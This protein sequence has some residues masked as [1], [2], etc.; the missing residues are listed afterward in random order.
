MGD[1][2]N[3]VMREEGKPDIYF[4]AHWSGSELP[5]I[6]R[7]TLA[8]KERWDD[9]PYLCRMVFC[10]LVKG[11]ESGSTGF[12]ISTEECD[13][14]HEYV[15]VDMTKQRIEVGQASWSFEEFVLCPDDDFEHW[16]ESF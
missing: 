7:R 11:S 2:G 5:A 3:I 9:A 12:G 1:R 10:E 15:I 13:N 16:F 8:K 14:Q 6:V 4:Y